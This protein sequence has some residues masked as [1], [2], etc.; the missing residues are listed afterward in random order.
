MGKYVEGKWQRNWFERNFPT[1]SA[2]API[3]GFFLAMGL[4]ILVLVKLEPYVVGDNENNDYVDD[5]S[6]YYMGPVEV[7]N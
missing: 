4:L 7:C 5:Y 3:L 2:L 1:L 6:C